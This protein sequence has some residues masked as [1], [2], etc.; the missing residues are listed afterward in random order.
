MPGD[1]T[2]DISRESMVTYL[3]DGRK[4]ITACRD[5]RLDMWKEGHNIH[6]SASGNILC[7]CADDIEDNVGSLPE[8]TQSSV[9]R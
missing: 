4:I 2:I 1:A 5:D 8:L 6:L 9:R 3:N 7:D